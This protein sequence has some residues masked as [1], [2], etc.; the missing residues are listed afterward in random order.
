M[1]ELS[2]LERVKRLLNQ[3]GVK[4]DNTEYMIL[5]G[6]IEDQNFDK[7]NLACLNY[8]ERKHLRGRNDEHGK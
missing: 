8:L 2:P 6:M 1:S 5:Q 4:Q 7:G 3:R